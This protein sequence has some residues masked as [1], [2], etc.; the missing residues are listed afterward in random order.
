MATSLYLNIAVDNQQRIK[1]E[2]NDLLQKPQS[3]TDLYE[4]LNRIA[5]NAQY[6]IYRIEE[7][8]KNVLEGETKS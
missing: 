8:T 6:T 4:A 3:I 7:H 1:N 2:V 5:E